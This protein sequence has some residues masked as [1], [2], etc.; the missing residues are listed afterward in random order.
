MPTP[1]YISDRPSKSDA[2]GR[3]HFAKSLAH[4][5]L[6]VNE[7]DGLV[8]G[9]EGSWGTGKSTVIGFVK[10]ELCDS[11]DASLKPIIVDFNPWMVSNTG[12]LVDTLVTQI[13]AAIHLNTEAPEKAIKAG[14]K[15]LGYVGL[16]KHLKH[17]K[18]LKYVPGI[19]LAVHIAGDAA[20]IA[21][22]IGESA[23]SAQEA[24]DDTE[25]LLPTLDLA[26]KKAEVVEALH[27][28]DR[29]IVVIVDDLDRL[30]ADEI[31]LIVQMI[32]A[33]ADFPGT[34]YLLAYDR[35]IVA[36]ALGNGD[37][38]AGLSYLEKI[39]QLAYPIPP[40]FQHQL[41]NFVDS[42]LKEVLEMLDLNLRDYEFANYGKAV[43]LVTRLARQ[44][45]DIVRLMNR[46]IL[47]LPA[48]QNEVNVVDVIVF[49]A[50]SLR[51]P[52]IRDSV[53]R[54]PVDFIG[55]TFRGDS[56]E[57]AEMNRIAW[58]M[59]NSKKGNEESPWEKHLPTEELDLVIAKK[60]CTFL[61]PSLSKQREKVPE[62]EL[63]MA[64]PDR[65]ARYFR[66]TSLDDVPEVSE[67]HK[68]LENPKV[69]AKMLENTDGPDLAFLLEW[70]FNYAPSCPAP[71]T[72]GS[73]KELTCAAS[74]VDSTGGLTKDLAQLFAKV[75]TLL[76]R[77]S[78]PDKRDQCFNLIV[79]KAPLSIS[80]P[81]LLKATTEQGKW[82]MC[83]EKVKPVG[84]R[85]VAS[86]LVVDEAI[87]AW[88]DRVRE[89]I[90]HGTL[91]NE[92]QMHSILYR[93][94]QLN[95]AYIET[96]DAVAKICLTEDGLKKFLSVFV[97]GSPFNTV[98][99]FSLVEDAQVLADRIAGSNLKEEYAWLATLITSDKYLN[100][101]KAQ[102]MR[103]KGLKGSCRSDPAR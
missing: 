16:L 33:V 84:M 15:L 10:K 48:I 102:A 42:K 55:H 44:P 74:N 93:F 86:G 17:L 19:G 5:L 101:I 13:A 92:T 72:Y 91:G 38:A 94:A 27:E 14:Q 62:H 41:R 79:T 85:L 75:L 103:F 90:Q 82:H 71:D 45:R 51:F 30:P 7:G 4:S 67:V 89:S 58:A 87:K 26:K 1:L 98:D 64:D 23:K 77:Q 81:I 46:L 52:T 2:L 47:S 70:I 6:F 95:F 68:G 96:Y 29:P 28:L 73:I 57:E 18:Y 43:E 8:V 88:S 59:T 65:L 31:R 3:N 9:I 37:R 63:R 24:L 39:V 69:L 22:T 25:K 54:H 60:A 76:L 34:T 20:E 32:K 66:M 40:L 53:H 83:P 100:A 12:A 36:N 21:E 97:E 78:S 99:N 35:E 11:N 49:E 56:D 80:E 50:L 61:F